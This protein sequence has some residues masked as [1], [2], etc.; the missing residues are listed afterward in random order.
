MNGTARVA[1]ILGLLI[2]SSPKALAHGG[3]QESVQVL[4]DPRPFMVRS[5]YGLLRFE[6]EADWR[7]TCEEVAG[8]VEIT[9]YA[10][11][12]DGNQILSNFQ[13]RD[14]SGALMNI[15]VDMNGN[16]NVCDHW[17]EVPTLSE[18]RLDG[19]V[20]SDDQPG[21]NHGSTKNDLGQLFNI[22]IQGPT[23]INNGYVTERGH[24]M[25]ARPRPTFSQPPIRV[26]SR[27]ELYQTTLFGDRNAKLYK[28]PNDY[29]YSEQMFSRD[30]EPMDE[31][32]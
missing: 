29:F 11:D 16:R 19:V 15:F 10:M 24:G 5:N 31:L 26:E 23:P 2:G 13:A 22:A 3:P 8:S 30:V 6:S 4:A 14:G 25:S 18:Y 12:K 28:Q 17:H 27:E 7:W 32:F 21:V 20:L 1:L 9:D